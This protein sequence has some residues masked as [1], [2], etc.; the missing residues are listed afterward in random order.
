MSLNNLNNNDCTTY[1]IFNKAAVGLS[2]VDNTSDI[3][4]PV[5]TATQLALDDKEPTIS[6]AAAT[7]YYRGDKS[8]V[9]LNKTAV[10]LSNVENIAASTLGGI[11]ITYNATTDK[12]DLDATITSTTLSTNCVWSGDYIA[13]DKLSDGTVSDAEF[14]RLNGLTSAILQTTDKNIASG[15]CPLDMYGLVPTSNLPGSV[16]DIIE[17]A[18]FAA[19]A[20]TGDPLKIYV[21]TDNNKS[22][23]WSGSA[24]F[25]ISASLVL[26]TTNGTAYD[27]ASGQAN[28]GNIALKQ[29]QLTF[30]NLSGLTLNTVGTTKSLGIDMQKTTAETAFADDEFML[31]EK[32]TGTNRLCRITKQQLKSSINTNTEY[33]GG[34]NMNILGT[35]I[36]LYTSIS[37]LTKLSVGSSLAG[38]SEVGLETFGSAIASRIDAGAIRDLLY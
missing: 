20:A 13:V 23:R 6:A 38:N 16:S 18:N 17:V 22:Y 29:D 15:L 4:K 32:T 26:G 35:A 33:F 8:F 9:T 27:G 1:V 3:A 2:N 31:I 30:G 28:A 37:G 5:S 34:T 24:Y 36:N 12:L 14:Q 10:G 7:D 19:L 11:N 21:T 25:E